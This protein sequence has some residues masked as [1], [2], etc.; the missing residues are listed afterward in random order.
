MADSYIN[1]QGYYL[2]YDPNNYASEK[3][4]FNYL[5]KL[6]ASQIKTFFD[7]AK[8]DGEANFKSDYGYDYKIVYDYSNKMY[9]LVKR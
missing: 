1:L 3:D 8:M 6:D 4:A 7:A 2:Y 5:G 9:T